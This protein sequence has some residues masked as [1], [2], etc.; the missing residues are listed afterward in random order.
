MARNYNQPGNVL[1]YEN[2]TGAMIA[3]G[4]VVSMGDTVGIALTAIPSGES[5]SVGVEGVFTVPKA[6]GAAWAQGKKLNFVGGSF[7]TTATAAA[8]DVASCAIAAADAAQAATVGTVKL[9]PGA[10]AAHS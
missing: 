4:A 1:T 3:A 6:A 9:A 2:G 8:G 5:G 7:R 10:G